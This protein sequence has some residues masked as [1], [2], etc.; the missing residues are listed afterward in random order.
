MKS[1]FTIPLLTAVALALAGCQ[2]GAAPLS[3]EDLAA[4]RAVSDTWAEDVTAQNW[5]AMGVKYTEDATMMPPNGPA[6]EG[7]ANIV[8]WMEAFPQIAE[9][10]LS[11]VEIDGYGDIAYVRGTYSMTLM[12]AGVPVPD[13]GK[14]LEIRR[15]QADGSWPMAIDIFNSDIWEIKC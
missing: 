12:L 4:I 8:A 13:T 15:K 10:S 14:Y 1:R 9:A 2:S 7:R 5:D 3:V 11:I 6:V